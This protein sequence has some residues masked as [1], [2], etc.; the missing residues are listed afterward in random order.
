FPHQPDGDALCLQLW[1]PVQRHALW[2]AANGPRRAPIGVAVRNPTAIAVAFAMGFFAASALARAGEDAVPPEPLSAR[3]FLSAVIHDEGRIGSFP[4][5]VGKGRHV[6]PSLAFV[7]AT[8][9]LIAL[10]PG[11]TPH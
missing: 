3:H 1:K 8:A 6:V 7:A 4:L 9:T 2:S 10:D 11:D 5:Q